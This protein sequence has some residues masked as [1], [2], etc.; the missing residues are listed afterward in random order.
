MVRRLLGLLRIE[1]LKLAR[2]RIVWLALAASVSAALLARPVLEIGR[3]AEAV[4]EHVESGGP[5]GPPARL[6]GRSGRSAERRGSDLGAAARDEG[7][8]PGPSGWLLL[9]RGVS[10]GTSV[11]TLFVLILAGGALSGERALGTDR[12]LFAR[13]VRRSEVV[14]AKSVVLLAFAFGLLAAVAVA[15]LAAAHATFG[16]GDVVDP[17]VP[18][19]APAHVL[20]T[21]DEMVR[22]AA[23]A[24]ALLAPALGAVT[25]LGL[26]ASAALDHP[27]HSSGL[28][29]GLHLLLAFVAGLF[30]SHGAWLPETLLSYPLDVLDVLAQPLSDQSWEASRIVHGVA[31]SGIVAAASLFSTMALLARRDVM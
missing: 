21:A 13:P 18:A 17:E 27:G 22:H 3:R 10:Q 5:D 28:A 29:I 14:L 30:P 26:L 9:A 23:L 15:S 7:P 20:R 8:A 25:L 4:R 31:G 16:L 19:D 6:G 11:L 12:V 1:A 2:Q 24:A